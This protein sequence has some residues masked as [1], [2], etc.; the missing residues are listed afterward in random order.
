MCSTENV[1]A[2]EFREVDLLHEIASRIAAADP[3]HDVLGR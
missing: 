2:N 3:L 1:L